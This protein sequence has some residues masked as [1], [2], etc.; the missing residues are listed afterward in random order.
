M[1]FVYDFSKYYTKSSMT[2]RRCPWFIARCTTSKGLDI[3]SAK[4]SWSDEKIENGK[5]SNLGDKSLKKRA[6][7][8]NTGK[9]IKAQTVWN[10]IVLDY[11]EYDMNGC[12][13][14]KWVPF[15]CCV[16]NSFFCN[17]FVTSRFH[18][19]SKIGLSKKHNQRNML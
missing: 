13:D 15:L 16:F 2:E 19:T 1:L 7:L 14:I 12:D 10:S 18:W 8:Y 11:S 4:L 3:W 9:M 17:L 5:W 6:I